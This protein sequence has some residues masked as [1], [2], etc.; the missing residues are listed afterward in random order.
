MQTPKTYHFSLISLPGDT[1]HQVQLIEKTDSTTR[2]A[3]V[4]NWPGKD[5]TEK[6]QYLR[7]REQ[8]LPVDK[9]KKDMILLMS[10]HA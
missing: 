7:V 9:I 5:G 10:K 3:K 4:R 2:G 6:E 8:C 1:T